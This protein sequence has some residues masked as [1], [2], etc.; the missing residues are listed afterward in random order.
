[1]Y[2]QAE[3]GRMV[4]KL[5]LG[6]CIAIEDLLP[7]ELTTGDSVVDESRCGVVDPGAVTFLREAVE[8]CIS[9]P[10]RLRCACLGRDM[11]ADPAENGLSNAV[12]ILRGCLHNALALQNTHGT[13]EDQEDGPMLEMLGGNKVR[14]PNG[15]EVHAHVD[16]APE[17][18]LFVYE[19]IFERQVY[20]EAVKNLRP[21][22]LVVDAGEC[23]QDRH[24]AAM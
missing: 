1:M 14:L 12:R 15:L 10:Q 19:E 6:K 24:I 17:E 7:Q 16:M 22:D 13:R 20:A 3:N 21:G 18:T 23:P 9:P 8:H 11:R 2:D 5:R 4:D